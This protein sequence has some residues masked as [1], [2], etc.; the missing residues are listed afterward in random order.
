[1]SYIETFHS[2]VYPLYKA[3]KNFGIPIDWLAGLVSVENST[4]NPQAHRF[5]QHVYEAMVNARKGVVSSY[6]PGFAS[7]TSKLGIAI[8]GSNVTD[9]DLKTMATSWGIGQIMGYH[10]VSRFNMTPKEIKTMTLA[11]SVDTTLQFMR[12]GWDTALRHEPTNPFK[13]LMRW[14]NTGDARQPVKSDGTP[15]EKTH[16]PNYLSN[17]E[18]SRKAYKAFLDNLKS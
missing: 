10:Y 4:I 7:K 13:G 6:F 9:D 8:H 16:S 1:M 15:Y 17:A 3:G 14:W 11:K 5:E 2:K 12:L 18:A